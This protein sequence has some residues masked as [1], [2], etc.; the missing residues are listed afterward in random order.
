[1][2]W[3]AFIMAL[4]GPVVKRVLASLGL[5]IVTFTGVDLAVSSVLSQAKAAWAGGLVGDAAQLVAMAG[6]NTALGI[7][8]GGITAR[9][10]MIALKRFSIL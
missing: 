6:G 4:V 2:T 3:A 5:G 1:M 10:T 8:A 9:V 7:I